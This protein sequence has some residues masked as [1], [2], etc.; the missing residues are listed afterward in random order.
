MENTMLLEKN[1]MIVD[2]DQHILSSL[3]RLLKQHGYKVYTAESGVEALEKMTS[4]K[5]DVVISDQRMPGMLG[6][7]LLE[8]V[9]QLYP[10]TVRMILSG[11]SDFKSLT[12][13]INNG[14]IYKFLSKPLNFDVLLKVLDEAF[15]RRELILKSSQFTEV[16]ENTCEAIIIIGINHIVYSVNPAFTEITGYSQE[17]VC[18]KD[19]NTL[20]ASGYTP[21]FKTMWHEVERNSKWKGELYG[22]RKN[23]EEFPQWASV[24]IINDSKGKPIQY[25]FSFSDISEQKKQAELI[26]YHAYHDAL[27]GLPDRLLLQDRLDKAF[28][29]AER[30]QTIFAVIYLDLDRFNM[31]NDTLGH[32]AGDVLL[33][34]VGKRLNNVI[35]EEDTVARMGGDE[36][37]VLI[38]QLNRID[39]VKIIAQNI[40]TAFEPPV[41]LGK[42]ELFIHSSLGIVIYPEGGDTPETL[43]KNAGAAMNQAKKMGGSNF[44]IYES[45]MNTDTSVHFTL[46][47]QLHK[48]ID[49]NELELMYQPQIETVTNRII[50]LEA[51]IRWN[52]PK[53]GLVSPNYFIPV[54]E[55]T[56]LIIPIGE[57]TLYTAC[58]QFMKLQSLTETSSQLKISINLSAKQ[59]CQQNLPKLFTEAIEHTKIEPHCLEIELTESV[60]MR[61]PENNRASLEKLKEMGIKVAVDDFGTGYSSL[62]YLKKFPIDTLKIDRSF[63]KD[64]PFNNDDVEI[65][66]AIIAMAHKLKLKVVAEGVETKEQYDFLKEKDCN[67][68]QGFF[69]SMPV[70]AEEIEKMLS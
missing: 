45:R 31:I 20:C 15:V 40:L 51:L 3:K 57:W 25:V 46:A 53:L 67:I 34:E 12:E 54:A 6:S 14:E 17:E 41:M 13:A 58:E 38:Q 63:I 9:K 42:N 47:N 61:Q 64:I 43:L 66:T 7:E 21:I 27:T 29:Q 32:D 36:F 59:F 56:G 18:G 55:E 44:C 52:H 23:G 50:G 65:V 16:F 70:S 30:H 19:F 24:S 68:I 1:L 28:A 10:E 22:I 11:Y 2:D 4:T 69:F 8:V 39:S 48:A 35:R 33:M 5:V 26:E 37:V 60:L 49:N 62:S